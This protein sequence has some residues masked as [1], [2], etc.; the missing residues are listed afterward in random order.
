MDKP[1]SP[2]TLKEA[3]ATHSGIQG[4]LPKCEYEQKKMDV[5]T[6][7]GAQTIEQSK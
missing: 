2:K 4:P 1:E 3:M 7:K 5:T 6:P